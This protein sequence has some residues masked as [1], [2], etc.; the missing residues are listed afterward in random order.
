[1]V[2]NGENNQLK[3]C[4]VGS[5][6]A[7]IVLPKTGNRGHRDP[8]EG[9]GRRVIGAADGTPGGDSV[10]RTR[11]NATAADSHARAEGGCRP[12]HL[13][14]RDANG[15]ERTRHARNRMR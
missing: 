13:W 12:R 2:P 8:A 4:S 14:I 1:M 11:V 7:L 3:G 15:P 9:R 6:S 10:L 5:R